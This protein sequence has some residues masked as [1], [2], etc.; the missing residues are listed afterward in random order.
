MNI[1]K[2]VGVA[3]LIFNTCLIQA[4]NDSTLIGHFFVAPQDMAG[5]STTFMNNSKYD[6]LIRWKLSNSESGREYT[7]EPL[8]RRAEALTISYDAALKYMQNSDNLEFSLQLLRVKKIPKG[9]EHPLITSKL[10]D[11]S[12]ALSIHK[13]KFLTHDTFVFS[14]NKNGLLVCK[15]S[16][17][18][19]L[20][21]VHGSNHA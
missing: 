12:L 11:G 20:L 1:K 15:A 19:R 6:F 17:R 5:K 4:K 21:R 3:I 13:S 9:A 2:R 10:K 14:L 8:L 7:Q 16:N 18:F